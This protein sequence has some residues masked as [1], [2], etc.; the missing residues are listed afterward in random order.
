MNQIA[1]TSTQETTQQERRSPLFRVAAA[2]VL[3]LGMLLGTMPA[4]S[5]YYSPSNGVCSDARTGKAYRFDST[6]YVQIPSDYCFGTNSRQ[7]TLHDWCTKSPDAYAYY[8]VSFKGPCAYHDMC[9]QY[10]WKDRSTCD[11]QLGYYLKR[12]C[13]HEYGQYDARRYSCRD[14]AAKYWA[15]VKVNTWYKSF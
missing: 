9:I 6:G 8:G 12:N 2:L 3:M 15:V 11:N 7:V 14:T 5:A 1:E 13:D 4:A 10:R